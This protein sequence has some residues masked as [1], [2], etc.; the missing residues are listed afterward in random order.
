MILQ[1]I[2][3][4]FANL[5]P[6]IDLTIISTNTDMII[7]IDEVGDFAPTSKRNNFMVAALLNRHNNGIV[8]K[9]AQFEQ[10]KNG[11]DRGKFSK[12]NEVKGSDLTEDELFRFTN[13]V[14]LSDPFI[15]NIQIRVIPSEN[16]L[17]VFDT[18]KVMETN[19]INLL[20]S[21]F[22]E[23]DD[24]DGEEFFNR[25]SRW[26]NHRNFQHYMKI[27]LLENCIGR[28]IQMAMGVSIIFWAL[29]DD[30]NLMNLE[31][32]IDKDFINKDGEKKYF[33]ELLRQAF[34]RITETHPIPMARELVESGHPF[35]RNYLLPRGK[36][37]LGEVFN[38]RCDF[39]DSHHHFELQIADIL[40]TIL[41]RAQNKNSCLDSAELI[42]RTLG[43]RGQVKTHLILNPDP[44]TE[45]G[46]R[47]EN[48]EP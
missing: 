35:V 4:N 15:R 40:G 48:D 29:R 46:I 38:G 1:C 36:I 22:K 10:W 32:K 3:F 42:D 21:H 37:N 24:K 28:S 12:Q 44:N 27:V 43:L 20:A 34:R 41:H 14:I 45:I 8:L 16:P 39:Y 13:E 30:S 9:Q 19:L 2:N 33:K 31:I 23:I 18:F 25:F 26:F 6:L 11:I 17:K 47:Y 7:A 5:A